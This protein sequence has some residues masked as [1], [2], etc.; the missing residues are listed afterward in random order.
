M[1]LFKQL[2]VYTKNENYSEIDFKPN[3]K[4][5]KKLLNKKSRKK[6][7]SIDKL[8]KIDYNYYSKKQEG[9]VL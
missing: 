9:E 2:N 6:I 3:K 7:K 5:L 4:Y 1:D 8:L